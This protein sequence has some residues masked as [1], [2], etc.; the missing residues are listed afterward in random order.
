VK[1]T[2]AREESTRY[3]ESADGWKLIQ[4]QGEGSM[5]EEKGP[6]EKIRLSEFPKENQGSARAAS[7]TCKFNIANSEATKEKRGNIGG[8]SPRGALLAGL[9]IDS[10]AMG[11]IETEPRGSSSRSELLIGLGIDPD[12]MEVT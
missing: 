10:D 12:T 9:N 2:E 3:V 1:A 8:L 7:R 11:D 6:I 5:A 4:N